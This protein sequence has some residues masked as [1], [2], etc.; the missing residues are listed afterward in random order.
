MKCKTIMAAPETTIAKVAW[1]CSAKLLSKHGNCDA[2]GFTVPERAIPEKKRK[3][4][5]YY[6]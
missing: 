2:S 4:N 6:I 5:V 1:L 3:N